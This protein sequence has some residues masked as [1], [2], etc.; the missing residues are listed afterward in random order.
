MNIKTHV[1]NELHRRIWRGYEDKISFLITFYVIIL[2]TVFQFFTTDQYFHLLRDRYYFFWILTVITAAVAG[3][4]FLKYRYMI[5]VNGAISIK[6]KGSPIHV[7]DKCFALL[8]LVFLISTVCSDWKREAFWGD[9]G[10]LQGFFLWFWYGVAYFMISRF[11]RPKKIH[12]DIFLGVGALIALW[13]VTDFIGFDLFDWQRYIREDQRGI[14]MSSF[15]N[16]NTFT[17][18]LTIYIS[19]AGTF[20]I[21]E[22]SGYKRR[23][24]LL[25]Y[26][27]VIVLFFTALISSQSDSAVI[28][29]FIF[30]YAIPFYSWKNWD[31]LYGYI[32]LLELLCISMWVIYGLSIVFPNPYIG[33]QS[34]VLLNLCG[35]RLKNWLL[36]F[37]FISQLLLVFGRKIKTNKKAFNWLRASW[38]AFG[39]SLLVCGVLIIYDASL[40]NPEKYVAYSNWLSF[41]DAWGTNRGYCWRITVEQ[42]RELSNLKK[43]FGT[44]LETYGPV[45]QLA[46]KEMIDIYGILYDSPHN[47]FLQY[48][49]T[50]GILG[51]IGY[52]GLIASSISIAWKS[53]TRIDTTITAALT[54]A[55]IT[56]SS[57]QL[58][59]ISVPITTPYLII[60]IAILSRLSIY[61]PLKKSSY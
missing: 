61:K 15:G 57:V 60:F 13:G 35:S 58:L 7:V 53:K 27:V 4:I 29:L 20:F 24:Y 38:A 41:S 47:E 6:A 28:G 11:Y 2:L 44:G 52:Y 5:H 23:G 59:N 39:I 3:L 32:C 45:M 8:L 54:M 14:F 17:A 42:F 55:I 16:I 19:V 26:S 49:F 1:D 33:L 43:L 46:H 36:C 22:S 40:G 34:G 56:Y 30:F 31:G 9:E 10:R 18:V 48:L 50:T 12:L 21:R 25:Y 51:A 37:C